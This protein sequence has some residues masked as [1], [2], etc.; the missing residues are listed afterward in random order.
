MNMGSRRGINLEIPGWGALHLSSALFD[1]NGTLALDGVLSEGVRERLQRLQ[2]LLSIWV[3]TADTHGTAGAVLRGCGYLEIV[4]IQAGDEARQKS[5]FLRKLGSEHT[6]AL[7]NG[8]NDVLMLRQAALGI[9]LMNG[10]GTATRALVAGDLL[11][12]SAEEALDLLLKPARLLATL[13]E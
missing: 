10:E 13:R 11:V 7:G 1:L 3:I 2:E 5:A 8:A 9:C 4:R 6:V 12:R